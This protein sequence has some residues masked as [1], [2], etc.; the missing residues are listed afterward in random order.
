MGQE[1][2]GYAI[3]CCRNANMKKYKFYSVD[4]ITAE[5]WFSSVSAGPLLE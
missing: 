4:N 1:N 5:M 2:Q 3:R